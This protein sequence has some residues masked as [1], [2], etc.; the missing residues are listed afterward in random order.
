MLEVTEKF[1]YD[2]FSQ[3]FLQDIFDALFCILSESVE[4][5]GHAVF[6]A[7]V[8]GNMAAPMPYT[9]LAILSS[10]SCL[11]NRNLDAF[12]CTPL[13]L[14]YTARRACIRRAPFPVRFCEENP[15]Y[16]ARDLGRVALQLNPRKVHA[17]KWKRWVHP[18]NMGQFPFPSTRCFARSHPCGVGQGAFCTRN[19]INNHFGSL[20]LSYPRGMMRY[21]VRAYLVFICFMFTRYKTWYVPYWPKA[22]GKKKQKTLKSL[23]FDVLV[24]LD[25]SRAGFPFRCSRSSCRICRLRLL[26]SSSGL[27]HLYLVEREIPA[28]SRSPQHLHREA[29]QRSGGP[30]VSQRCIPFSS[31]AFMNLLFYLMIYNIYVKNHICEPRSMGCQNSDPRSYKLSSYQS[32]RGVR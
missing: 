27:H 24:K 15:A 2:F 10:S 11:G 1:L 3:Q 5:Y 31:C 6:Q 28:L 17:Y 19:R 4:Q 29:L 20:M 14:D 9:L 22:M 23:S 21:Q 32:S 13:Q 8:R 26:L 7:L 30:Q 12:H 18:K 25:L 16:S